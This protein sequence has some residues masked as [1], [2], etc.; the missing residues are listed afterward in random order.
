MFCIQCGV[1][2]AASETKCP[3]CGTAV[4]HPD[5]N[6]KPGTPPYPPY[7]KPNLRV[8]RRGALLIITALFVMVILQLLVCEYTIF[9]KFNWSLYASGAIAL[10]YVFA[11]L[12]SWFRRPNPVIFVPCDFVAIGVYLLFINYQ[13]GGHW[14]L[15]FAFPVVAIFG[16]IITAVIALIRYVKRGYFYILGGFMLATGGAILLLEFFM[17][18]TFYFPKFYFWSVY[19]LIG[20]TLIGM[21]LIIIGIC[22]PLRETL[23][24]KFFI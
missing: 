15:S 19:P 12:P 1:E 24:K 21:A 10:L 6:I 22:K 13:T 14:F 5:L 17:N 4:Y 23:A 20:F 2:L 18:L 7:A 3:L 16:M 9:G 11:I 8:N